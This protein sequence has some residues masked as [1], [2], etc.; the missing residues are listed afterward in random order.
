MKKGLL[1]ILF[2][3]FLMPF[4]MQAQNN[5]PVNVVIDTTACDTF[6]WDVNGQTYFGNTTVAERRGDTLYVLNLTM[7]YSQTSIVPGIV[8]GGC[9]Y[10]WGTETYN[11]PG[12][13]TQTFHTVMGGCDSIVTINLVLD[14]ISTKTYSVT[15]CSE[16]IWH[17]DTL[18]STNIYNKNITNAGCDS[19]L[20][21]NLTILA[22]DQ[23]TSDTLVTACDKVNFRFSNGFPKNIQ[24]INADTVLTSEY[25]VTEGTIQDKSSW[26]SFH[27]RTIEQCY[28][29]IRSATFV[30]NHSN[31]TNQAVTECDQY[32]FVNGDKEY[33]YTTSTK[34][35]IVLA[36]NV[37]NCDSNLILTVT[38][39]KSPVVAIN[40]DIEVSPNN[41]STKLYATADQ[42][43][44]TY[45]WETDATHSTSGSKHDTITITNINCNTDVTAI[46][47]KTS[48]GC[49]GYGYVTVLA[50]VAIEEVE[51]ARIN[52]FPNPTTAIVNVECASTIN[53]I[54]IYNVMGQRLM[55][56]RE[57]NN[58]ASMDMSKLAKGTYTM[59][60]E[61]QNGEIIT[62]NVVVNK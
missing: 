48:T 53:N 40:G 5:A 21:L 30:I 20:T 22:P 54:A 23:R 28:D 26:G 35:T 62:R 11:T 16:Y 2:V 14:T 59:R 52:I 18:T 45:S 39:H 34:D 36:K 32:V 44:V 41:G 19:I 57:N 4:V 31:Y 7:G 56:V 9:T 60:I 50:N 10:T 61:L 42:T 33:E 38:I 12:T 6:T 49:I 25:F 51:D 46:A 15:A 47:T 8:N 58:K 55:N 3:A 29:S 43:G 13:K 27:K 24:T 1:S 37:T 17:G